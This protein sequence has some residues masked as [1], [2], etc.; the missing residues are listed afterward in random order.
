MIDK[1]FELCNGDLAIG[2]VKGFE[3]GI[4]DIP[5]GPSKYNLE[6]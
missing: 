1:I 6:R 3:Q 4:I 5:F 2:T